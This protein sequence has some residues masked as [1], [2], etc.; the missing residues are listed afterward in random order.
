MQRTKFAT[1]S[2]NIATNS[3]KTESFLTAS[4]STRETPQ[5]N[6]NFTNFYDLQSHC[7]WQQSRLLRFRLTTFYSYLI[8]YATSNFKANNSCVYS[9]SAC[10]LLHANIIAT[11]SAARSVVGSESHSLVASSSLCSIFKDVT[12][13][14]IYPS[15]V[16]MSSQKCQ[17]FLQRS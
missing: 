8:K 7:F 17:Q 9:S 1:Q 2:E 10:A 15:T 16:K 5:F 3:S 6:S 12:I 11:F 4:F 14:T 13:I